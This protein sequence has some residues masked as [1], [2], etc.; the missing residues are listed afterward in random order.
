MYIRYC[1]LEYSWI[2]DENRNKNICSISYESV[3][4]NLLNIYLRV[5]RITDILT[6]NFYRIKDVPWFTILGS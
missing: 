3:C 1:N 6:L 2:T 4:Y 5:I